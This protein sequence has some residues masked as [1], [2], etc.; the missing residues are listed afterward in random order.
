MAR[1][2]SSTYFAYG[3][4]SFW[5]APFSI[6]LLGIVR[7]DD[8]IGG[9]GDRREFAFEERQDFLEV[10]DPHAFRQLVGGRLLSGRAVLRL[11]MLIATRI[12]AI[13]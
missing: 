13:C 1:F 7:H 2:H 9:H 3:T 12:A 11:S 10:R 4:S 5:P 8:R 6:G